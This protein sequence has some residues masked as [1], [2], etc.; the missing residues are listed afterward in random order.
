M[1]YTPF[2]PLCLFNAQQAARKQI[3]M[4]HPQALYTV[5]T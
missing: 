2:I 1:I 4:L 3:D 5:V